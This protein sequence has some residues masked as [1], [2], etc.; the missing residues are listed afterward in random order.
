MGNQHVAAGVRARWH[1]LPERVRSGIDGLLG[2]PVVDAVNQAGGFSPGLAARVRCADGTRVFV[3][4]VGTPL[5][6]DSPAIHRAEAEVTRQLPADAPVP[7][8]RGT[9]DDGDWVAM[10]F[11]EIDGRMPHDPWRTDEFERVLAA[12]TRLSRTLTPCPVPD[13]PPAN[14]AI[15]DTMLSYRELERHPPDDLD[16]WEARHLPEL[17]ALA[18][19]ALE[20]VDGDTLVHFD[21]RA[22]NILL[23]G[24]DVWFVDWPWAV[25]GAAWIDSVAL[26]KNAAFHG[27]DPEPYLSGHPLVDGLAPEVVTAFVAGMAGFFAEASRRPA[28]PGL[29]TLRAFQG[30]Q[31]ASTLAWLRRRLGRP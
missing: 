31:H 18:E 1:D 7:R 15:R 11:D 2:S 27:H 4:A 13:A 5:N 21:L 24:D 26:L 6:H 10:V 8:L 12:V 30:A 29:P 28:P 9:Y 14:T 16:P 22:D 23:A 3:K 19:S 17:A 25:R 20:H